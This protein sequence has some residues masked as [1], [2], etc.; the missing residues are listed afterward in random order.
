MFHPLLSSRSNLD[1][2]RRALLAILALT[3]LPRPVLACEEPLTPAELSVQVVQAEI[4]LERSDEAFGRAAMDVAESIPC[5]D[6]VM[7]TSLAADV[8]RLVGIQAWLARD[9]EFADMA[10]T[11]TLRLDPDQALP[12]TRFP[13]EDPIHAFFHAA[14]S[15][16]VDVRSVEATAGT[17]FVVDGR[18]GGRIPT[19]I[20]AVV[21]ILSDEGEVLTT[22]YAWPGD[23]TFVPPEPEPTAVA[24]GDQPSPD[25]DPAG[26]ESVT[27]QSSP[28]RTGSG[29]ATARSFSPSRPLV[30]TAGAAAAASV[31]AWFVGWQAAQAYRAE[32]HTTEEY[33]ALQLRNHVGLAASGGLALVAVGAG[34]GVVIS[35]TW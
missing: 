23:R 16:V 18:K 7:A 24:L 5:L 9:R 2:L 34:A 3:C 8:H 12:A 13:P 14:P 27:S 28:A 4:A 33:R 17:Y 19:S 10:F 11:A 30:V 15:G 31:A 6:G 1:A 22:A 32:E 25:A 20:P 21:Q 35:S 26:T 29:A